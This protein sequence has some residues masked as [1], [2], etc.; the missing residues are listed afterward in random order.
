M[1]SKI[2]PPRAAADDSAAEWRSRLESETASLRADNAALREQLTLRDQALDATP[3]F[4]VIAEQMA[5]EPIIV[6]C[7]KVVADEHGLH[8]DEL[9]GR[10]I[11]ALTQWVSRDLNYVSD[12]NAALRAGRTFQHESEVT[13]R[14]GSKFWLGVSIRPVFDRSGRVTHSVS[15]G[16]DITAKREETLKKQALQDKL[17][18]EM[19]ERARIGL[20]LQ[21]AQRLESV[22]RLAAGIAHEINTPIQYV[23]DGVH[24]LRGAYHDFS[25]L[26]DGWR[27]AV[28]ALPE[29]PARSTLRLEL[30]ALT[31]KFDLDFLRAEIPKAFE[32][33]CGGVERVTDIVK[34]MR[35]FAHP[36]TN[37][38]NP[39][40]LNHAI[41]TTLIVASNEY[42]YVAKVRT[43]FADLPPVV[44]NIGEL[45]QVFL[46][47]IVNAAHAI[48][49]AGRDLSTG[50]IKIST[51]VDDDAV[52]I[53]VRDNGCG[54]PA[55]NLT[56]LYDPFFTTKEVGRGTG[57]GLAITHSIV[58]DKHGGQIGVASGVGTGTEFALRLPVAGRTRSHA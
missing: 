14:D 2:H 44:C 22:G 20:E 11:S 57:Q 16:A 9:I 58:V 31:A 46:N 30:E 25:R 10:G 26:L 27:S 48:H 52:I 35:E 6:Y 4:L 8:R 12:V 5:P 24:F 36:G 43:E 47:L 23:G 17:M 21:L 37:E 29:G 55:E 19:K 50:E 7:N 38:H 39:A 54:V 34:A 3:T 33:T 41:G 32:R 40:D 28:D 56:K 1:T 49:D 13:R 51:A 15:M 45:N 18:E 53:R 42:R